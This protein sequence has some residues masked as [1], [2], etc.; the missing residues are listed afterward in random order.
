MKPPKKIVVGF[1]GFVDT[2]AKT[3]FATIEEFGKYLVG[4]ANKS[5]SIEMDVIERRAG[6]NAPIL[7]KGAMAL[8]LDVT[9]IGMLGLPAIEPLFASSATQLYS[10]ANTV[11]STAL[12]FK[13]G[14]VFLA[15]S[16]PFV[17]DIWGKVMHAT[18][19]RATTLIQDADGLAFVNWS[20]VSFSETLWRQGFT[21]AIEPFAIDKTKHILFDLCDCT[22]KTTDE[23]LSVLG[24]IK[25]F[26][27]YRNTI[28]SLNINEATDISKKIL[29]NEER[30]HQGLAKYLNEQYH[31]DEVVVHTPHFSFVSTFSQ[32]VEVVTEHIKEPAILTGAGDTFNS[33]YLFGAIENMEL[34]E[35]LQFCNKYVHTYISGCVCVNAK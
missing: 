29:K 13:D 9:C 11:D 30:S 21:H 25:Q 32:Q 23:V 24:L 4:Q 12:E 6:G 26:S 22:R 33:A 1:D 17:Q 31:I 10:Y 8:G 18:N 28:L 35:R 7:S 14:K 15:A 20:E 3:S 34:K 2:I 5:C 27:K 19:E 16:I